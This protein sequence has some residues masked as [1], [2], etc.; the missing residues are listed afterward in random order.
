MA[1][2]PPCSEVTI[3][4]LQNQEA[5]CWLDSGLFAFFH[6]R[7]PELDVLFESHTEEPFPLLQSLY[8]HYSGKTLLTNLRD[9]II[10]DFRKSEAVKTIFNIVGASEYIL[11]TDIPNIPII[12]SNPPQTEITQYTLNTGEKFESRT[13]LSKSEITKQIILRDGTDVVIQF[14]LDIPTLLKN[15]TIVKTKEGTISFDINTTRGDDPGYFMTPFLKYNTFENVIN[16]TE[17]DQ[18]E[19]TLFTVIERDFRWIDLKFTS[20]KLYTFES[21]ANTLI[22]NRVIEPDLSKRGS[23]QFLEKIP[24]TLINEK[25]HV[26][27]ILDAVIVRL[28][29]YHYVV[30]VR[31]GDTD[32]WVYYNDVGHLANK[33]LEGQTL[34]E[35]F[36]NMRRDMKNGVSPD[37]HAQYL[38]YSRKS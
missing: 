12:E 21:I 19:N 23:T 15:Q 18:K 38:F 9:S 14:N 5:L 2:V 32:N 7:R 30:Y 25:T 36:E 20:N 29:G 3:P 37:T 31:C 11:N 35:G 16:H 33:T 27:F 34:I 28:A 13:E 8:D 1:T 24:I 10:N 26:E 22:L 17:R 6:K 4:L